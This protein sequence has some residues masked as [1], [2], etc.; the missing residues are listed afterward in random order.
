MP[1]TPVVV[2]QYSVS[3][4]R[5]YCADQYGLVDCTVLWHASDML[6]CCSDYVTLFRQQRYKAPY[7]TGVTQTLL[8]HSKG[9]KEDTTFLR[10]VGKQA[11]T[12]SEPRRPA[13]RCEA[14]LEPGKAM[15]NTC[16]VRFRAGV[17]QKLIV[18]SDVDH[19]P[20]PSGAGVSTSTNV[21]VIFLYFCPKATLGIQKTEK[22]FKIFLVNCLSYISLAVDSKVKLT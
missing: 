15:T 5:W 17:E 14:F 13:L 16:W 19:S 1:V 3:A 7:T 8:D 9:E 2:T 6:L 20:P 12:A 10:T 18:W 11:D 4:C 22:V 21:Y